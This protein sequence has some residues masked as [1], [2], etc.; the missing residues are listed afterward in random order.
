M[1]GSAKKVSLDVMRECNNFDCNC[2]TMQGYYIKQKNGKNVSDMFVC[3]YCYK[4]KY[5]QESKIVKAFV[6][7]FNAVLKVASVFLCLVMIFLSGICLMGYS[8]VKS[9]EEIKIREI[10]V[11]QVRSI[12]LDTEKIK[13]KALK[14]KDRIE[15]VVMHG[16]YD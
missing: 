2:Y 14:I 7:G 3:E 4:H 5:K 6:N 8:G 11:A 10:E 13:T 16:E 15:R 12:E 9:V 1:F